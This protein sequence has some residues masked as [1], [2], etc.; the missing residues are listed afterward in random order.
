VVERVVDR[1]IL[2]VVA[3]SAET[4]VERGDTQVL[5]ERGEVGA[6]A[7]GRQPQVLA[8]SANE[9]STYG[10]FTSRATWFMNFSSACEP[11]I[12]RKPRP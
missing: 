9:R 8:L 1:V 12:S 11:P 6:G 5:E 3:F 10:S 7:E 4:E 2:T